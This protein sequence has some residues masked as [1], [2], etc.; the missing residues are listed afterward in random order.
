MR[1]HFDCIP[2]FLRQALDAARLVS[3][4]EG[5]H[6]KV[7]RKVLREASKMDLRDP[8]PVMGRKIHR[9]IRKWSGNDDPYRDVKARSNEQMMA[10]Y[11]RLKGI[12][13]S[14]QDPLAT[15]IRLSISGN[16]IDFGA[17]THP[18]EGMQVDRTLEDAL[19]VPL[20][21]N[22]LNLFRHTLGL[23]H[24]I[25]F[26]GDNAGEIVLDRLLIEHLPREKIT[27][28]V[29]GRAVLNDA[30]VEDARSIGL[31]Q[32]VKVIDNGS[33]AP[34][35]ILGQCSEVFLRRF[36]AADLII[37]KGQGNYEGLNEVDKEIFFLLKVKCPVIADH[38]GCE[39]GTAVF[40][41]GHPASESGVIQR[42]NVD[43][44]R[45]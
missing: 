42:P 21:G 14:S 34:G 6:E 5:V 40:E 24:D 15:A 4:D 11:P 25:L 17:F 8:P 39:A 27:Y 3:D 32:I 26:L 20:K 41:R 36:Q 33:D 22:V 23:A 28:V 18:E 37:S 38:L 29:R 12:V 31:D 10:L 2:C 30:T 9:W 35:T 43:H 45:N 19:K 1:T 13:R 7:L 44:G 16:T